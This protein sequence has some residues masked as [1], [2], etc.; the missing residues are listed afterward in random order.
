MKSQSRWYVVLWS[1][2][3]SAILV[4]AACAQA[5]QP[6]PT[7]APKSET[8][9][10]VAPKPTEGT[11]E[12]KSASAPV[13]AKQSE[14]YKI[15]LVIMKGTQMFPILVMEDQGFDKKH[16]IV[17]EKKEAAS[18]DAINIALRSNDVDVSLNGWIEAAKFRAQGVKIINTYPISKFVNAVLVKNDS[19]LKSYEEIKGKNFGSFYNPGTVTSGILRVASTKYYGFDPYTTT[20]V[21]QGAKPLLLGLLD[22]GDVDVI[23]MGEP[24][25][26]TAMATGK[27]RSLV[28]IKDIYQT[29]ANGA[30][31]PLQLVVQAQEDFAVK[32]PAAMKAFNAALQ[33]SI[34]YLKNNS[35]IWP[36]LAK[37]VDIEDPKAVDILRESLSDAYYGKAWDRKFIDD[38][39]QFGKE[40]R[41]VAGPDVMPDTDYSESFS[42]D[43]LP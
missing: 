5:S 9:S 19:P 6:P 25:I 29:K 17:L 20:Q 27:Y 34:L 23:Y 1:L 4:S 41:S 33:D 21:R 37:Q 15:R 8:K 43:Y 22:K 31:V 16:G 38:A 40:F 11:K 35:N 13:Q 14:P 2:V 18:P 24:D 42:M 3:I 12:Q 26:S 30:P 28:T 36:Q 10:E 39:V 32:N 7:T